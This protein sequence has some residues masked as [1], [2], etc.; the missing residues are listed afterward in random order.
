[1][2]SRLDLQAIFE[3]ILGSRNVYFSP[4]PSVQ[5]SYPAIR[6]RLYAVED[7]FANDTSYI[8]RPEYEAILIDKNPESPH[9]ERILN[10]PYC[11]FVRSYVAN[12]LNH[13]VFNIHI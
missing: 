3:E 1:M 6:Y 10:L 4:P 11:R 9:F 2:A 5:M 7:N 8:R 12:N 13:F